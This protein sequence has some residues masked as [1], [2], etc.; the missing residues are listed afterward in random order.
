MKISGA[1]QM[2]GFAKR[3]PS[4]T[5]ADDPSEFRPSE[6]KLQYL[7]VQV[8]GVRAAI[9]AVILS[10][11][12]KRNLT[13]AEVAK[14]AGLSCGMLSKIENGIHT[15]SLE[16]LAALAQSLGTPLSSLFSELEEVPVCNHL[17]AS[18]ALGVV[19]EGARRN[20]HHFLRAHSFSVFGLSELYLV[21][22]DRD[23]QP[24]FY[25][26]SGSVFLHML[27]GEMSYRHGEQTY[28]LK[29]GETL[30]FDGGLHNGPDAVIVYP[31]SYLLWR[32]YRPDSS[33][34]T[35]HRQPATTSL[36]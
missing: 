2:V 4:T 31:V 35:R 26:Q 3:L 10:A 29:S 32:Q 34:I 6:Q 12:K 9:G 16:A 19:S 7:N 36:D 14:K 33:R 18:E 23:G 15:P 11:R 21:T 1:P 22:A 25:T 27:S 8:A 17:S 13:Q 24:F 20:F 28:L 30:S 5:K